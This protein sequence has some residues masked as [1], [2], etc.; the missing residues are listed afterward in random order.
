[1]GYLAPQ[2][3]DV[4]RHTVN[5]LTGR[6]LLTDGYWRFEGFVAD[7]DWQIWQHDK[8]DAPAAARQYGPAGGRIDVSDG[9][10]GG[11]TWRDLA[12]IDNGIDISK[13]VLRIHYF[14]PSGMS[15]GALSFIARSAGA[16]SGSDQ[17]LMFA[18]PS[19]ITD[20]VVCLEAHIDSWAG[21]VGG[22]FD[23]T[24]VTR[25]EISMDG[26]PGDYVQFNAI[27]FWTQDTTPRVFWTFDDSLDEHYR[28]VA[29]MLDAFGWRGVF[30]AI[31]SVQGDS[32]RTT[33]DQLVDMDAR[34]HLI[35]NHTNGAANFS[36]MTDAEVLDVCTTAKRALWA[37]GL[38]R[39]A[40]ILTCPGDWSGSLQRMNMLAG[41][42]SVIL[43][44]THN[45]RATATKRIAITGL[46]PNPP[47]DR[48]VL[49]R[50][51]DLP[52]VISAATPNGAEYSAIPM[53]DDTISNDALCV[54]MG[55]VVAPAGGITEAN[56]LG[57]C[58]YIK[59]KEDAGDLA[60]VDPEQYL[61]G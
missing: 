61:F 16:T 35:A 48:R 37:H 44:T 30:S 5:D 60:V 8:A 4:C 1:M 47:A 54:L 18:L 26:A 31:S 27:E 34:G 28:I 33:W 40:D 39:G 46:M 7:A 41:Y 52:D 51:G 36:T 3:L 17:K 56:L 10:T 22:S 12:T 59:A 57:L 32:G 25:I 15:P 19:D 24:D 58:N 45:N 29:P 50:A 2:S 6:R 13:A 49:W 23:P 55:H 14:I 53:I 21:T 11:L 43:T 42:C 9:K 20:A 38:T